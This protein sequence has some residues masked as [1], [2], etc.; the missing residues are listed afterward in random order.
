MKGNLTRRGKNSWRLKFDAVGRD[1]ATGKRDIKYVTIRAATRKQAQAE[2]AKI[3]AAEVTGQF[4][5]PSAETVADFIERWLTTWAKQNVSGKTYERYA[6]LLRNHVTSRIGATPIQ[7][8]RAADLQAIYAAMAGL[9]D[10]T[11]LHTHRVIHR[12]LRHAEQ[13]GVVHQNVARRVDAPAVRATEIEVLTPPQVQAV[14]A[15]L[16][17]RT[18]YP[19]VAVA[20][21]SGARRGELL[22]LR[23][24]DVDLEAGTMRIERALE[25]TK[26]GGIT[27]KLPKTRTG[28]RVITLAPATVDVLRSHRAAV[29]A[30][31]LALGQ[32]KIAPTLPVF[33]T[34][35]GAIRSP[36]SVTKEWALVAKRLGIGATFH[37][38]R[39]T[40]ASTL[41]ASG[42]DVLT[43]SRR[44]G[45]GSP[46]ITLN[47]YGHLFRPDD[48]AAE[49]MQRALTAPTTAL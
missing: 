39:H 27:V 1:P 35:D 20:L 16:E 49:I 3:L 22:A 29:Q 15:T 36:N 24:Q 17:G 19:I 4:V 28:K 2:A 33:A 10:R 21:G 8:L 44:L 46:S 40:H 42:L 47:T 31:R 14:L 38:L 12:M 18:L 9:S 5:D 26:S 6:D 11:R 48:R 41:I 32:G 23:W 37:S 30:Q 43:I 25:Q 13:W 7:R 45:H 34:L